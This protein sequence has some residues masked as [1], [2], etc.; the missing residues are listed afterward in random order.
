[1]EEIKNVGENVEVKMMELRKDSDEDII[2]YNRL[3]NECFKDHHN[4]R[5]TK[6][7]E[8]KYH[9]LDDPNYTSRGEFFAV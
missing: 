9:L 7:E 5:P 3:D 6:I 2:L 1:M 4:F 8:T